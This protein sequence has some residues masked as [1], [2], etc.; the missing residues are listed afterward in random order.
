MSLGRVLVVDDQPEVMGVL[1][2]M[3]RH[4]QYEASTAT[5]AEEAIAAMIDARPN[6]VF[7]DLQLPGMSGLEALAYFREH[8]PSVPVIVIT[9]N[10][11][12]KVTD[13]VRDRGASDVLVKPFSLTVLRNLLAQTIRPDPR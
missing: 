3:L 4:L 1:R 10:L 11:D 2:D 12:Q 9:G 6:V 5:S 13:Q 7:L 8:Y